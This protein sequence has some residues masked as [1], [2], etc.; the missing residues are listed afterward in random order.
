MHELVEPV[1]SPLPALAGL[2]IC[3]ISV[4]SGTVDGARYHR[5]IAVADHGRAFSW[6]GGEY[7]GHAGGDTN[8]GDVLA[9][10]FDA[11]RVEHVSL[12]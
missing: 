2:R 1:V 11:L 12:Q 6:L 4:G 10:R 8:T 9:S 7:F 3:T 5:A